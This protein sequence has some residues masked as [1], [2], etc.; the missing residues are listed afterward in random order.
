MKG[1]GCELVDR[2]QTSHRASQV[3]TRDGCRR[4][5]RLSQNQG[6]GVW[7]EEIVTLGLTASFTSSGAAVEEFPYKSTMAI[8]VSPAARLHVAAGWPAKT[9]ETSSTNSTLE[10]LKTTTRRVENG[11]VANTSA[12]FM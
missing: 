12:C 8:S 6:N 3:V 2:L 7:L 4:T 9:F 5:S 10:G 1:R 11:G